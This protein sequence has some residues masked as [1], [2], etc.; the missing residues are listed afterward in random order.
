MICD[1]K[2][3]AKSDVYFGG[4]QYITKGMW[5]ECTEFSSYAT[6]HGSI[7]MYYCVFDDYFSPEW[8][9][10]NNFQTLD[11]YRNERLED[12]LHGSV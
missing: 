10:S 3:Y 4:S 1:L 12:I 11:E 8:Y 9:E 2:L 5:Y 7:E 6:P